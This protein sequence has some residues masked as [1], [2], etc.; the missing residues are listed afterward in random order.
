MTSNNCGNENIEN[1][2]CNSS[3]GGN[4]SSKTRERW[5]VCLTE[6][7]FWC[8]SIVRKVFSGTLPIATGKYNE[9]HKCSAQWIRLSLWDTR[10]TGTALQQRPRL[11]LGQFLQWKTFPCVSHTATAI[12]CRAINK[13]K[14]PLVI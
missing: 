10:Q 7:G 2:K 4:S 8:I 13:Y 9:L 6:S 3:K 1:S 12:V 14:I 5:R 11:P